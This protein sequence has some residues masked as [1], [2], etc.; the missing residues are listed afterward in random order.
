MAVAP[1]ANSLAKPSKTNSSLLYPIV[2]LNEQELQSKLQYLDD[3]MNALET[4]SQQRDFS[5]KHFSPGKGR[6]ENN[7]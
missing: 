6:G 3:A 7:S 4:H 1:S 5:Q 2:T